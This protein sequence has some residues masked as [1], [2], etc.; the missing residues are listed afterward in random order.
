M[1]THGRLRARVL[2]AM[3]ELAATIGLLAPAGR[4]FAQDRA[5]ESIAD[6][7]QDT[8]LLVLV[9]LVLVSAALAAFLIQRA[10]RRVSQPPEA[11]E[12]ALPRSQL[13]PVQPSQGS[14]EKVLVVDDNL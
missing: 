10:S 6:D 5:G 13:L 3:L 4:A 8:T 7:L 11:D 9:L 2:R 1:T 14:A 12:R